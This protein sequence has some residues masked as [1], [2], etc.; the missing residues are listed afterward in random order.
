M[1]SDTCSFGDIADSRL[2]FKNGCEAYCLKPS[3][4]EV[5]WVNRQTALTETHAIGNI[6]AMVGAAPNTEWLAG[7]VDLDRRRF[8][9]TGFDGDG[10][11]SIRLLPSRCPACTPLAVSDPVLPRV[12]LPPLARARLSFKRSVSISIQWCH[13][14]ICKL[15]TKGTIHFWH[16]RNGSVRTI[17]GD[18]SVRQWRQSGGFGSTCATSASIQRVR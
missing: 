1:K 14:G 9:K 15:I 11:Y 7:G 6:F 13:D 12:L 10:R 4:R 18:T 16:R 2:P 3:F 17:P 5:T 8:L